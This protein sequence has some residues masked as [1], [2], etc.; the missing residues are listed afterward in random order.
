MLKKFKKLNRDGFTL[1]EM[2]VVLIVIALLMAIIMPNISG[3]KERIET[4]AKHNIAQIIETQVHTYQLVEQD[5]SVT[6]T[7][8]LDEG[9]LTAKQSE[10]AQRLL[11]LDASAPISTPILVD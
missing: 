10:E 4:Q 5:D 7:E 9:Y 1:L 8:L 6:L 11:Q 3:Q 2:L